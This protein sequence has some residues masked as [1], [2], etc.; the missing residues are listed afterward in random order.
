MPPVSG[1]RFC[2]RAGPPFRNQEGATHMETTAPLTDLYPAPCITRAVMIDDRRIELYWNTQVMHA[3]T[4]DAFC[5]RRGGEELGLHHWIQDDPWGYG[6]VYQKESLRTTLALEEPVPVEAAGELTVEVVGDVSD[7]RDRLV[8]KHVPVTLSYEPYYTQ[9]VTTKSGIV[10]KAGAS[11]QKQI[12]DIAVEIVDHMLG[13]IPEVAKVLIDLGSDIAVYGITEDA[14]DVPEHRMGYVLATR[15]VEGFGGEADQ[16]TSSISASNVIRL[17]SGRYATMYPNEMI[18][19]HEFG[20]AIHLVGMNSLEDQTW[21]NRVRDAY[22]NAHE[23]GL[24]PKSYASSN[25]EEYFA[26]LGTIWFNVMQEGVDGKWDGI[27]GPVNTREELKEYDPVGYQL[28][29]D[30]YTADPLPAPW[31]VAADDYDIDGNP[32]HD[33]VTYGI[34]MTFD[35]GFIQ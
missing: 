21:A 2:V 25:Y 33:V 7:Y 15:H 16:P 3:D 34:D 14:Y 8:E 12:L 32:R 30:V 22:A 23:K 17:R 24:W 10:V 19:V 9:F 35:W 13:K 6:T 20:H 11:V 5:V 27:R 26:T 28:M 31:N 29:A 1:V 4:E 18:L